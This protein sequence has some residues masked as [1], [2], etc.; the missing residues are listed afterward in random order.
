MAKVVIISGTLSER[1]RLEVVL[2]LL[3][4]RLRW[5]GH[6]VAWIQARRLPPDALLRGEADSE[7]LLEAQVR[8]ATA[9]VVVIASPVYKA[10]YTGLLKA[11]LDLLPQQSLAGK[12]VLP[13]AMGGTLAHLLVIDY[14]L[15]PVLAALGAEHVLQGVYVL[16]A[17][18]E[19]RDGQ[20]VVRDPDVVRRLD[21]AVDR[22]ALAQPKGVS[23]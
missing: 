15:R 19:W 6:T 5:A 11:Y 22:L 16:D 10:S 2:S 13:I 20:G 3:E 17:A 18:V 8:L 7:A 12:V 21:N 23:A 14:A 9:D 1:S 4:E